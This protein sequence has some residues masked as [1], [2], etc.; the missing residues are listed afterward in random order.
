[1]SPRVLV[2]VVAIAVV[3]LSISVALLLP[4]YTCEEPYEFEH[5]EG[6]GAGPTCIV[7][8]T[9]YRPRNWLPTKISIAGAGVVTAV[10]LV[11]WS[12][13]RR[14]EVFGLVAMFIALA[15]GWYLTTE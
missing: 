6:P 7:S 8:D 15:V 13:M 12:R 9:G 4:M 2:P 11:L 10:S 5:I 14:P 1:M 3:V